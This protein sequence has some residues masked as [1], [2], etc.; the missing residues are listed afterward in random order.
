MIPFGIKIL[1]PGAH[2]VAEPLAQDRV[3]MKASIWHCFMTSCMTFLI[4]DPF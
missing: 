3:R 1:N 4:C 2:T